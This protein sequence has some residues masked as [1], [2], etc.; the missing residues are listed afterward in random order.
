MGPRSLPPDFSEVVRA[1]HSKSVGFVV[2]ASAPCLGI[3]DDEIARV[4]RNLRP[5]TPPGLPT[6]PPEGSW[7]LAVM[8][9]PGDDTA[10]V[11]AWAATLHP[12]LVDRI[13]FYHHPDTDLVAALTAWYAAGLPDPLTAEISDFASFHKQFGLDFNNQVYRDFA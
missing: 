1:H 2:A 3:R 11:A 9:C 7:I 8:L 6:P 12:S 5:V 10:S 13:R 4:R